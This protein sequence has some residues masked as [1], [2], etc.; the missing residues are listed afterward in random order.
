MSKNRLIHTALSVLGPVSLP[1]LFGM[2]LT[3]LNTLSEITLYNPI[4]PDITR[5]NPIQ[6][7]IT[8]INP[9]VTRLDAMPFWRPVASS[10]FIGTFLFS[11]SISLLGIFKIIPNPYFKYIFT[12]SAFLISISNVF[13]GI[14][15][16]NFLLFVV[17]LFLGVGTGI[18]CALGPVY[19]ISLLGI[20]AGAKIATLQGLFVT[21]G[22]FLEGT[23][24]KNL[25]PSNKVMIFYI[26]GGISGISVITNFLFT[27][28]LKRNSNEIEIIRATRSGFPSQYSKDK[29]KIFFILS[30]LFMQIAQQMTGINPI[31]SNRSKFFSDQ[32]ILNS[33]AEDFFNFAG[34]IG[35]AVFCII[36]F[37]KIHV[38][39]YLMLI[40]GAGSFLSLILMGIVSSPIAAA[41]Y[42]GVFLVFFAMGLASLPWILP[43][44][45]LQ[46]ERNISI[47][48]GL[49]SLANAGFS[50]LALIGFDLV[51]PSLKNNVFFI[52]SIFCPMVGI[53]GY[54]FIKYSD[55]MKKKG[56]TPAA[57][58]M[59][60]AE[61]TV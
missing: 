34:M 27:K 55:K 48:A 5:L 17:R 24:S 58:S 8:G 42:G 54:F 29:H 43:S 47:A 13:C 19:Y 53:P 18:A 57:K 49:G 14:L 52:F 51:Y 37:L 4:K 25:D 11:L 36:I 50:S 16:S 61:T 21:L 10:M 39:R 59:I 28:N 45:I 20:T 60:A 2:S 6:P 35:T 56:V 33:W 44:M 46:E 32:N 22:I 23:I 9:V 26:I 40:S 41:W 15:K 3:S 7:D 31:L 1:I 30:C 38:F 12:I